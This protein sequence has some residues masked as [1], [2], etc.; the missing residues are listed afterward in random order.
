MN[1][2]EEEFAAVNLCFWAMDCEE[3]DLREVLSKVRAR[4]FAAGVRAMREAAAQYFESPARTGWEYT[5]RGV[6]QKIRTLPDPAP[7]IP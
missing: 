2:A 3:D 1:Y 7:E 5:Q 4:A 6:A